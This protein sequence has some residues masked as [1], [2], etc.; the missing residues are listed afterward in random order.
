MLRPIPLAARLQVKHL[1]LIAAIAEHGQLSVAASVLSL[2]QPA[3]SRALAEIEALAGAR[4]FDR[5]A[6]GMAPTAV[7]AGLARRAR[8]ILDEIADAAE[9]VEQ[10]RLGLGGVVRV[11]AVTGAAVA[12]VV[13]TLRRL[14]ALAPELELHVEVAG[15]AALVAGLT[16]ARFDMVLG[17]LP[18]GLAA[19][20]FA[21]TPARGE[22]VALLVSERHPAAGGRAA[23]L[24]ALAGCE[25]VMQGPGAPVR[26]AVEDAFAAEGLPPPGRVTNTA[27][28][29]VTL[30]MLREADVVAPVSAEVATLLTDR[31]GALTALRPRAPI[32]VAPYALITLRARRL[33]PA[34]ARCRD[35]LTEALRARPQRRERRSPARS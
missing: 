3:A 28:L 11:G 16:E 31:P 21:M 24:S 18:Q 22:R 9:E 5:R 10:L 30:A 8:A 6:K 34:A 7:G 27:S 20:D 25:W 33:S 12:C 17:R 35:M 26:R 19:A 14:R 29:L 32:E 13:P 15:S 1:R 23:P 4:L 2:T